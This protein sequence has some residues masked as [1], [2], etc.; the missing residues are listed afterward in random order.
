MLRALVSRGRWRSGFGSHLARDR[1][2]QCRPSCPETRGTNGPKLRA[3]GPEAAARRAVG[4]DHLRV[5]SSQHPL[6]VESGGIH[7]VR[8]WFA[9]RLDFAP[10][11]PFVGDEDFPLRRGCGGPGSSAMPS[12]RMWTLR[13]FWV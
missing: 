3:A 7:Q 4:G 13:N 1:A 6:D 12:C 9:G 10:E 11:V 8:P 5:L 2:T